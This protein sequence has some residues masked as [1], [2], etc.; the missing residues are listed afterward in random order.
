METTM[1]DVMVDL[2]TLGTNAGCVILSIGAVAFDRVT[3]E[4]GEPY[5]AIIDIQS[6]LDFNLEIDADTQKWWSQ[7]SP[8]ARKI[9][10]DVNYHPERLSLADALIAFNKFL[11]EFENV[12]VWGNGADF[13]NPILQYAYKVTG[14][15]QGW[16][17]WNGRCF[18]TIKDLYAGVPAPERQG[19]HHNALDDAVYQATHAGLIFAS[20]DVTEQNTI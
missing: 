8:E 5:Y 16:K 15:K 7:Q 14:V 10:D 20:R 3:G 12:K 6:C 2:E 19:T 18:R 13:D 4:L 9:L 17:F 11:S 1:E